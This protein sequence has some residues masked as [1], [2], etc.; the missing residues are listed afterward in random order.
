MND[1]EWRVDDPRT[2]LLHARSD[3]NLASS[4]FPEVLYEQLCFHA[5]QAAEK[6]IKAVLIDEA[7]LFRTS[8]TSRGCCRSFLRTRFP[9]VC[10]GQ[11]R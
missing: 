1:P 3:L 11:R 4:R 6:S 2:W 5:Q 7:R 9:P 8:T 10:A